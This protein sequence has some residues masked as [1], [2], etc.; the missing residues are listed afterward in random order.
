MKR[1]ALS[2]ADIRDL[3]IIAVLLAGITLLHYYTDVGA[4]TMHIV[5]RRLFYVPIIY[6]SIRFGLRGGIATAVAASLLF[7]PH[8]A[9]DLSA[10]PMAIDNW[11]EIV[12]FNVV[13]A[14]AGGLVE[15][16]R[17]QMVNYQEVSSQLEEAYH[18]L[19]ERAIALST[20]QNYTRSVLESTTS[21]VL[22]VDREEKIVTCN[23]AAA[24]IFG[25]T[26]EQIVGSTL[27]E[28]CSGQ[29]D[30]CDQI[31][32]VLQGTRRR[33]DAEIALTNAQGRV[34]PA[35][36]SVAPHKAQGGGELGAVVT[37]EDLTEVK[38]LTEQL[39]RADRLAA[40]GEVV[41]GVAHEV[42]NPLGTIK[43]SIQLLETA[44]PGVAS[45]AELGPVM[46]QEI[47]RLDKVVKAFLDFGRPA[48]A[49][50]GKVNLSKVLDD[51][52]IFTSQ[53]A[54]RANVT[55]ER[56]VVDGVAD[57]W[58]DPDKLKQV[59][60]N[61]IFNAVQSMPDGGSVRIEAH[62]DDGCVKVTVVDDGV[63]IP[64]ESVGKI[65]DPFFTTR[66]DGTGLGL[67]IVHRIVD[68]H[69]GYISVDSEVGRGSTFVV[70][71]PIG[72][73]KTA[74]QVRAASPRAARGGKS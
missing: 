1:L 67:A 47:D 33:I 50:F 5:Y 27:H 19:E 44:K 39:L 9:L 10:T 6:A 35:T 59:F 4:T 42:R 36:V 57:V 3:S 38:E 25:R 37:I 2:G 29:A 65:W 40:M 68:E 56:D 13:G 28:L 48:K 60:V 11:F 63:G 70:R 72:A 31:R 24:D 66:S 12:L 18:K 22:S 26:E 62:P 34:V 53:Y 73:G 16:E 17:R 52:V 45:I 46:Q 69:R 64:Q 61:L 30:L 7:A 71:L 21:G 41:A 20:L 54:R 14:V 15:A 74:E 8:V 49:V 32:E 55:I 23:R 51:V 58:A 43:A